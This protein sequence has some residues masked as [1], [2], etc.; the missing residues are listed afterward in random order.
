MGR[1][2]RPGHR[3]LVG[4]AAHEVELAVL[5][6]H[7]VLVAEGHLDQHPAGQQGFWASSR[8]ST[9]Q[10]GGPP[11]RL[12]FPAGR[13]RLDR[14]RRTRGHL[15]VSTFI[16]SNSSGLFCR[17]LVAM[18]RWLRRMPTPSPG[19]GGRASTPT[20]GGTKPPIPTLPCIQNATTWPC[21][22]HAR[23]H[24]CTQMHARTCHS[25]IVWLHVRAKPFPAH[26][27][28]GRTGT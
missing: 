10:C 17:M 23:T 1:G 6:Q 19:R 4:V 2:L 18:V 11:D 16:R 25:Q 21:R 9:Q 7:M 22:T 3:L 24:A 14:G 15:P 20:D 13:G 27:H 12:D 28:K 8:A 26:T 5:L